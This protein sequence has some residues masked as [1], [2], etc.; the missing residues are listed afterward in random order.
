MPDTASHPS[1]KP[2]RV[3]D[4]R[5]PTPGTVIS[6]NYKGREYRLVVHDDHF[7]LDGHSFRSLSEAA[8]HVTGAKWNGWLFWGLTERKRRS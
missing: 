1:P 8:R 5:M 2:T 7:E 3:R 6:R 4:I